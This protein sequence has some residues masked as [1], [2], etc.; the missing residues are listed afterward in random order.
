[1]TRDSMPDESPATQRRTS[2][3]TTAAYAG[4]GTSRQPSGSAGQETGRMARYRRATSCLLQGVPGFAGRS[5][6][7]ASCDSAKLI[8]TLAIAVPKRAGKPGRGS[9]LIR[10]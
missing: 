2:S 1:M 10:T 4:S 8:R 5:L 9:D 6:L 7:S 3:T